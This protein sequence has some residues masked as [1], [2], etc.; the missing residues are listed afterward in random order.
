MIF[1]QIE[2]SLFTSNM[3]TASMDPASA[4]KQ[5]NRILNFNLKKPQDTNIFF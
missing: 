3:F 4:A 5:K 1:Q 2:H